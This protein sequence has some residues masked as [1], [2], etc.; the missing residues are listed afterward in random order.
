[1]SAQANPKVVGGFVIGAIVLIIS[2]VVVFSTGG[3]LF[4]A[5]QRFVL[6]FPEAVAGLGVGSPVT[7]RGV[8]LGEVID[9]S[10]IA[11]TDTLDIVI[12]VTIEVL[13]D[14]IQKIGEDKTRREEIDALDLVNVGL[15]AR[16]ETQSLVTGQR[17]IEFAL[18]PEAPVKLVDMETKYE[19][20][21]TIPS[22]FKELTLTIDDTLKKIQE[23][24]GSEEL[25]GAIASFRRAMD[26]MGGL[27][28]GL[29]EKVDPLSDEIAATT[30]QARKTMRG[31]D[32]EIPPSGEA[33]RGA[34]RQ[35]KSTFRTVERLVEPGSTAQRA[36]DDLAAA[37]RA[38]RAFAEILQRNPEALI[39]GRGG[40]RR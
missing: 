28:R 19:Q 17:I 11:D 2:A 12:P 38:F 24:A 25:R 22:K 23:L 4:A 29:D 31:I 3:K 10:V 6:F 33:F 13:R 20:L 30:G 9:I 14:R 27:A 8:R 21:P 18:L 15:R 36:L 40:R 37:A 32:A 5:K 16:L 39:Q 7:F 1:M 26:D 34:M 35:G